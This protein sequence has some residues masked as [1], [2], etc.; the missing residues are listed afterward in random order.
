MTV[1]TQCAV[2]SVGLVVCLAGWMAHNVWMAY[3][4]GLVFVLFGC[5]CT[6]DLVARSVR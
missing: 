4:G 5:L 2:A 1:L 3:V 6:A